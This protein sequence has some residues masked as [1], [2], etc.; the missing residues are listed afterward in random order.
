M[1]VVV[2]DIL[3]LRTLFNPAYTAWHLTHD[4]VIELLPFLHNRYNI[5]IPVKI[6][7][8][9]KNQL[10]LLLTQTHIHLVIGVR[11][12]PPDPLTLNCIVTVLSSFI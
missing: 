12:W 9:P 3:M 2:V 7:Q 8:N 6:C 10:L 4:I 5:Y 11:S 1:I